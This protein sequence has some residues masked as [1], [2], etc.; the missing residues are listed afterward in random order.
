MKREL[1][2]FFH[3][4]HLWCLLGGH[5]ISCFKL[6]EEWLWQPFL[7]H[8]FTGRPRKRRGE[9]T[10]PLAPGFEYEV[11]YERRESE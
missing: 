8:L 1:Q 7:R 11:R 10:I 2:H 6:Y 3:P 9:L 4:L 5:C